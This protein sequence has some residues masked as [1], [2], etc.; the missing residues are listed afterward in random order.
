MLNKTVD[1]E[2]HSVDMM[3]WDTAGQ[4]R[5]QAVTSAFYRKAHACVLV[6]SIVARQS[7]MALNKWLDEIKRY[8]DR[9]PGARATCIAPA[10]RAS[11]HV[12]VLLA[13]PC[14]HGLHSNV[15]NPDVVVMLV[16]NKVDLR[17]A[18]AVSVE[19]ASEWAKRNAVRCEC[20]TAAVAAAGAVG[21]MCV[22]MCVG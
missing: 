6:Y 10:H 16:G 18:R 8:G 11:S 9:A 4:E 20:D 22:C 17:H 12:I 21:A 14:P 2:H 7:F 19:E 13:R 15:G 1:V 5:Y 3:F